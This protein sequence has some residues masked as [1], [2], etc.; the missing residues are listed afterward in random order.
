M[1]KVKIYRV[2]YFL[3]NGREYI[4]NIKAKLDFVKCVI[5]DDKNIF[6]IKTFKIEVV[7]E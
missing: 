3:Y 5:R 6:D 2:T 4:R 7:N 1:K